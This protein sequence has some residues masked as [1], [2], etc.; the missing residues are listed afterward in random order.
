MS[1]VDY[2]IIA[3]YLVGVTGIGLL[4]SR[5]KKETLDEYFLGNRAVP[6]VVSAASLIA[7]GISCRS[8]IGL[9]GLTYKGDMTYLQMYLPLPFAVLVAALVFL[10]FYVRL[11]MTSVYEYVGLRFGPGARS[12]ASVLFQLQTALITGTVIAAPSLVLSEV[13]GLSYEL[14]V[15]LLLVL[16]VL[17][18]A[19]GG[20]KA[21]IWTD[22]AQLGIFAGVPVAIGIYIWLHA[23][24]GLGG[25]FDVALAHGKLRVFDFSFDLGTEVTFWS[26]LLSMTCWHL[27]NFSVNQENSQRYLTAPSEKDCRL[28]MIWG[29]LGILLIWTILMGLGVMLY[30]FNVQHPG[31]VPEGTAADRIF[32]SF[33]LSTLPAGF[34]GCFVAAALAAGMATLASMINAMGTATLLDVWKLHFDDGADETR[35][36]GRARILMLLWGIASFGTAFV[37]LKFGTVITAGIKIGAVMIGAQFGMFLLGMFSRRASARGVV[38]G[39][40]TGI[41]TLVIVIASTKISWAWYCLIGTLVT[42]S[43]GYLA[44]FIWPQAPGSIPLTWAQLPP[45]GRSE[46]AGKQP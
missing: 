1:P 44:S 46:G 27:A 31:M 6:W 39:A 4:A 38:T 20:T 34:K 25:L 3:L 19:L 5:S 18:T 9:P 43:A 33:V 30:A 10:P 12:F 40:L 14:S 24:G 7:T 41:G 28:T 36:I 32:P 22:L 2:L 15:A 42:M 8:L 29:S 23:D 13:T 21:I 11:R 35:W 37:V 45:T 16:T 17:Y 26:A